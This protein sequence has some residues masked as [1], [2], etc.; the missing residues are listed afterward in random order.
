MNLARMIVL[1]VAILTAGGAAYMVRSM[2]TSQ[3]PAVAAPENVA[4]TINTKE[5]LVSSRLIGVGETLV[6]E[7]FRWQAWPEDVVHSSYIV[8]S[9]ADGSATEWVGSVVRSPVVEG[10]PLTKFKMVH[11]G[12]GGLMANIIEPGKRGLGISISARSGAGGFIL[13]NDRVD[14]I[15]TRK[16][17]AEGSR[18]DKI[19]SDTILRDIRV[20][21]IDQTF[22]EQDGQQVVVGRTAT[23]ELSSSQ[24]EDMAMATET[25]EISLALRSLAYG[26]IKDDEAATK[27]KSQ[28]QMVIVRNGRISGS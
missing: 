26:N 1:G 25:G 12:E 11:I 2:S 22:R 20:L 8:R 15:L 4:A 7:D 14:V 3:G 16:S 17:R 28:Q 10:E 5:V 21:A 23:L 19:E 27:R 9:G 18:T 13:P 6:P 24:V